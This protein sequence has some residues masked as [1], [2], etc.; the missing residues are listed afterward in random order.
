[1]VLDKLPG[2]PR[3]FKQR[4]VRE[5]TTSPKEEIK[6][7]TIP[8]GSFSGKNPEVDDV[9]K[10]LTL[11]ISADGIDCSAPV[12]LPNGAVITGVIGYGN[13]GASAET[14][15]LRRITLTSGV[16]SQMA[17]ANFNTEDTGIVVATINNTLY[18]YAFSTS[19]LDTGDVIYG[20]RIT[21]TIGQ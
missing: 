3:L 17:T 20:A 2:A 9:T 18:C 8:G 14:W 19:T 4:D 13:A 11:T 7:L 10:S 16:N 1:M 6:N 12:S 21:Y 5:T 15:E